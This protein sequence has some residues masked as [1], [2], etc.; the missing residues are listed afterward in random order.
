MDEHPD[1][2]IE[3]YRQRMQELAAERD[4]L[5][6]QADGWRA[7]NDRHRSLYVEAVKE[8]DDLRVVRDRLR[9]VVDALK[10]VAF[11][12]QLYLDARALDPQSPVRTDLERALAGVRPLDVSPTM[13]RP[14]PMLCC[15]D[16]LFWC[17]T[18]EQVECSIHGGFSVCCAHPERHITIP[19]VMEQVIGA[20]ERS[21]DMGDES[22][23]PDCGTPRTLQRKWNSGNPADIWMD[24]CD[25]AERRTEAEVTRRFGSPIGE[26]DD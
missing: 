12:A 10:T 6:V 3:H 15:G 16:A 2:E 11:M 5:Q 14:D 22:T 17:P 8:R 23:C 24:N 20:P 7:E 1:D 4:R 13:G 26:T 25:C 19:T 21:P 9:A 18:V